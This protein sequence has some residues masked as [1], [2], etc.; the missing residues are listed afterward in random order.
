MNFVNSR[1]VFG[2]NYDNHV[3]SLHTYYKHSTPQVV[4]LTRNDCLAF[5]LIIIIMD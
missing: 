2:T 5:G 4:K 3:D 1:Y